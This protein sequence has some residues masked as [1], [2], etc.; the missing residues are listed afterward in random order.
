MEEIALRKWVRQWISRLVRCVQ[1][2]CAAMCAY[3]SEMHG[4]ECMLCSGRE[5]PLST[6]ATCGAS[7]HAACLALDTEPQARA[8]A[9]L[10]HKV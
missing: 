1:E 10:S 8:A 2:L 7:F 9:D 3:E 6:C 5:K 4:S